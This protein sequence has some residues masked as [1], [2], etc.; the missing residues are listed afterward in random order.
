MTSNQ[1]IYE[2]ML[3]VVDLRVLEVVRDIHVRDFVFFCENV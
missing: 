2:Y 1:V 3:V